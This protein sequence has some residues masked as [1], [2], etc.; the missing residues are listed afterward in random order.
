MK[1]EQLTVCRQIF[2]DDSQDAIIIENEDDEVDNIEEFQYNMDSEIDENNS[3]V[4][5]KG[6]YDYIFIILWRY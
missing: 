5:Y 6:K 3:P 2:N 4:L 1:N